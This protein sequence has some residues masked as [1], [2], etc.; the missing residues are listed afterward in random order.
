QPPALPV[1]EPAPPPGVRP[2][3]PQP[4]SPP[5]GLPVIPPPAAT[6]QEKLLLEHLEGLQLRLKELEANL[7][8]DQRRVAAPFVVGRV[9]VAGFT[10]QEEPRV[11]AA[12]ERAG[13]RPGLTATHSTI[14]GLRGGLAMAG[15]RGEVTVLP[16]D[17]KADRRDVRVR[18]AQGLRLMPPVPTGK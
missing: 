18:P 5:P 12:L 8:E 1:V 3:V 16:G 14:E 2:V 6:A 9:L 11:L 17:G 13:V 15:L 4:A 7:A 10:P